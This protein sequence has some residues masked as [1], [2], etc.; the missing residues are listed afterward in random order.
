MSSTIASE[1]ALL[2][3]DEFQLVEATRHP[4]VSRLSARELKA[5]QIELRGLH[6][7]ARTVSRRKRREAKGRS[8]PRAA[9]GEESHVRR[10]KQVF[11]QALKRVNRELRRAEKAEATNATVAGARRALELKRESRGAR[12]PSAGRTASQGMRSKPSGRDT[13]EMNRAEIGRVSQ[14]TKVAQARKDG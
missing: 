6:D 2:S 1:R 9:G 5:R 8:E 13:V 7:K 12:H 11:A 3:F 4:A 14:A 10:R